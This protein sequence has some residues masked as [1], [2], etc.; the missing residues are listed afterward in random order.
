MQIDL[1]YLGVR[2]DPF[3][4]QVCI[5]GAGIAGLVL[6]QSLV[7]RGIH[8]AL[9]EAGG[10]ELEERSQSLYS[11]RMAALNH[12]GTHEG[13]FR[14][15]G[16]S[17]TRWGGQLLPYTPDI[18]HPPLSLLSHSWP[19][20]AEQLEPFYAQVQQILGV[21]D[22]P[23]DASTFF[24]AMHQPTPQILDQLPEIAARFSKWAPFSRRNL[25]NSIAREL[26]AK[27]ANI[28][29]YLHANLTE[30]LTEAHGNRVSAALISNYAGKRFRFEADHFV[31]AA[32]TIETSRLLLASRSILP[33]GLGNEHD[34]VGRYFFDHLS[35]PAAVLDGPART[36]FLRGFA[37][38]LL[39]GTTHTAKLE[40]SPALREGLDM[41][42]IM[43]HITIEEPENSGAGVVRALL[44]SLQRGDL[45]SAF[46]RQFPKL[47]GA[48]L[49]L[50]RLAL[51]AKLHHRRYVSTRATVTLR[52]DTEQLP[53]SNTRIRLDETPD[54]L[55]VPRTVVDWSFG[56]E[57]V[58][59]IRTFAA[60]LRERL[61]PPVLA[62]ID[63][64]SELFEEST[65][66]RGITDT[67]HP[68]GGAR[69]GNDPRVSVVDP[70]LK[71]HAVENLFIASA[72]TFP[73]GGSS[74]P[75][76]TLMALSLRLA[77]H[78]AMQLA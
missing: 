77:E 31:L 37:P 49:D 33:A 52:I 64:R 42:A 62:P 25:A 69:M 15:L 70:D 68:M 11:A 54:S 35:V 19:I 16:G 13:R 48:S 3:R 55:G 66:L 76:F 10:R 28:T 22:L 40:A 63:W 46:A 4:S 8:V 43:A 29:L 67:Y 30:F 6:A 32:G 5:V 41:L 61:A 71:V 65:E 1:E 45:R 74:N 17:S 2:T 20:G 14:T 34:Q 75:T 7:E 47:P 50:A 24:A 73:A 57:E 21:D 9:L 56:A 59:T 60:W 18:F 23:F 27:P 12:T 72:A 78:L 58:I 44:Q 36:E 39:R 53:R 51:T 26:I 38:F